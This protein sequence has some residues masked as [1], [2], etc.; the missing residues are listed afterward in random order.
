[1]YLS[2]LAT[3]Y[4]CPSFTMLVCSYHQQ[5]KYAFTLVP[6]GGGECIIA[7]D[8]LRN[9]IG[10]IVL[11]SGTHVQREVSHFFLRHTQ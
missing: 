6:L 1:M 8:T 11:E 5:S 4:G 2:W 10:G 7:F 3:S 9:I